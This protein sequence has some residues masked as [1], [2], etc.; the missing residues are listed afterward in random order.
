[1]ATSTRS[2]KP[3]QPFRFFDKLPTGWLVTFS[4]AIIAGVLFSVFTLSG[5][6][7][8]AISDNRDFNFSAWGLTI[9]IPRRP[10]PIPV[11]VTNCREISPR[12]IELS[13]QTAS[14][15]TAQEQELTVLT[16]T[17][18]T[19]VLEAQRAHIGGNPGRAAET[20]PI[21]DNLKKDIDARRATI[22]SSIGVFAASLAIVTQQCDLNN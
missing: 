9:N 16:T 2:I 10:D 17:W 12:L 20:Q 3:S 19:M 8:Q 4:A 13:N 15:R 1:M 21:R 6:V 5:P 11:K 7:A 22:A 18:G 14:L